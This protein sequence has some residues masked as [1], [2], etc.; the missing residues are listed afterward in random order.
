MLDAVRAHFAQ[1]ADDEASTRIIVFSQ[2]RGS[3][4]EIVSVLDQLRPLARCEAFIGQSSTEPKP[5]RPSGSERGGRGGRGGWRGGRGGNRG[6]YRGGYRGSGS[7]GSPE[8]A[9]AEEDALPE[10]DEGGPGARG[11]SQKEQLAVLERFREGKTN[12]IVATCV[13][14]EG[15]DIGEV[16]LIINYDAP[17]SPIRLLQRIGRTGRARRGKVIVFLAKDTREENSYKK[18][19][20]EYKSVQARIA[21]GTGLVLRADLSPPMVPPSL[22]P[23]M[24]ARVELPITK[25]DIAWDDAQPPKGVASG[26]R[27]KGKRG[28]VPCVG[29]D[30]ESH[31]A[32]AVLSYKYQLPAGAV[33]A[34]CEAQTVARL[35]ERG[36]AWQSAASPTCLFGHSRRSVL[37]QRT[38]LG[39]ENARFGDELDGEP[40]GP[41]VGSGLQMPD[42][43]DLA[44]T[45]AAPRAQ[46]PRADPTKRKRPRA[47][48][49]PSRPKSSSTSSDGSLEEVSSIL[50]RPRQPPA[51]SIKPASRKR[52]HRA[53]P[54]AADPGCEQGAPQR[55]IFEA[56]DMM[57]RSGKARPAFSWSLAP[58]AALL[59]EA[60]RRGVDLEL[61]A[62][63]EEA[64]ESPVRAPLTTQSVF[65]DIGQP[66]AFSRLYDEDQL[67]ALSAKPATLRGPC[68]AEPP[69]AEDSLLDLDDFDPDDIFSLDDLVVCTPPD[70]GR[71][72]PPM[73]AADGSGASDELLDFGLDA[74]DVV[75]LSDDEPDAV[76]SGISGAADG[77][78]QP[79][80]PQVPGGGH[81]VHPESM[82]DAMSSS[83]LMR[84][85]GMR[86]PGVMH[87]GSRSA[88]P[89]EDTASPPAQTARKAKSRLVRGRPAPNTSHNTP[90]SG[91]PVSSSPPIV[92]RTLQAKSTKACRQ[93]R[94]PQAR[95][96]NPFVD[97]E[98]DIGYSDDSDGGGAQQTGHVHSED[99]ADG[100]D[101][102]Q[103]LSSFIVDDDEV[104]FDTPDTAAAAARS[105]LSAES[106]QDQTPTRHIGDIY[107]R[108]LVSP[109]TPVTEIMRQLAEREKQRRWVSDTPTRGGPAPSRL[110]LV[111]AGADSGESDIGTQGL[112]DSDGSDFEDAAHLFTQAA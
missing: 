91:S 26:S 39:L 71:R 2:Y 31:D 109:T 13:G 33:P 59:A 96:P 84:R 12:I 46:P 76:G 90:E 80:V 28:A 75:I 63:A 30:S 23:G 48:P 56:I 112:A 81:R 57:V 60:K 94:R 108:S 5:A 14:E 42:I 4:S 9:S 111:S 1:Q 35:L 21:A 105:G 72:P 69:A 93:G 87:V 92:R 3:V 37:Y 52:N 85:H 24:P 86:Q 100:D 22:P 17:S 36:I 74:M 20:R 99:E 19:Q 47:A 54:G 70:S 40:M 61:D 66:G 106:A 45:A 102:D 64:E 11:Q 62:P 25:A 110:D 38:M 104:E 98:A 83:P 10:L 18:A 95:K 82:A 49:Q 29:I 8:S 43:S 15:L 73:A 77:I 32:F 107:R 89:A 68:G 58:D 78:A 41:G 44:G 7:G 6:G 34:G 79:D 53:S 67:R 101:L 27:A 50:A 51:A 88:D 103:N 55:S 65:G 16:D 97:N